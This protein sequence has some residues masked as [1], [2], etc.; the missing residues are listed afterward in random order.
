MTLRKATLADIPAISLLIAE[1]VRH[2]HA[3]FY[4]PAEREAALGT[5]FGVDTRLIE[6]ATYFVAECDGELAG[7]GGWSKRKTLFGA[8]AG[9]VKDDS[10]LDPATD[11]ARVRAFF[12]SPRWARRGIGSAIMRAC[13]SEAKASG[14]TRLELM[15]TLPGELLYRAHGFVAEERIDTP[16]ALVRMSKRL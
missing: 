12:V 5:V 1:S 11:P 8:D 6:D 13:E 16:L 3:G 9:P 14:F 7:C 15:A 2:L 10:L 4:T